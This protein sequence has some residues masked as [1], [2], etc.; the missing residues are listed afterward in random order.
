MDKFISRFADKIMGVLSG[1]DR[2]VFRGHLLPLMRDGGLCAFLSY[3]GVRLLDFKNFVVKT[4]DAIKQA[5]MAEAEAAGRPIRYLESSRPS[6]EDLAR[7]LL[8]KHPVDE[9]LICLFKTVEPCMSFEY[10]RSPDKSERGLKLRARKCLHIYKYFLHPV[11]G[12]MSARLQTWFPFTIQVC[13]NGREWLATQL[14]RKGDLFLREDNCVTWFAS[15]QRQV[16]QL[17]DKQLE[18][19]WTR[20][21]TQL[22]RCL[23]PLHQQ[24][25]E[26]WPMDYY[27]SA[28]QTEWATDV[29]F[30]N[31]RAL[32]DVYPALVRHAMFHLQ[33]PDVMRFL[34]RK[35]LGNFKGELITSFKNRPEGVRVK[36]WVAGNSIKMYDKAAS[37]LRIET[38]IGNVTP[39]KVFRPA[40]DDQPQR[41]LAWRPLRKGT[42]DLY[43]RTQVSQHANDCYLGALAAASDDT[44]VAKLFDEVSRTA[45]YRGRR[46]RALRI[47]DQNDVALLAAIA[48][49]EWATAG[50]RNRDLRPLLYPG[51]R[52]ATTENARKLSARVSRQLRLLRAH[53]IINKVPKS[54]RYRLTEKGQL[55]TATLFAT[56]DATV[57]KLL[58]KAAA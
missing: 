18:T 44:K 12:F 1:F 5:A 4:S 42:A 50:F 16:Q 2:V 13:L 41:N 29:L 38:T 37:V 17:F 36:H 43:R 10:H 51:T 56:R 27:W 47:G 3:A 9:G 52:L 20:V 49:G 45:S 54:H 23:N 15:A 25:F 57:A 28:Y 33:S 24:I 39:F 6:K 48:R 19:D 34:G 32:A 14:A 7:E 21:L 53:G 26:P 31:P 58:G 40:A 8:A 22:A 11:F 35:L 55:L 46:V 30:D